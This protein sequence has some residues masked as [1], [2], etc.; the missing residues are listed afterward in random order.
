MITAGIPALKDAVIELGF[1]KG[2]HFIIPN[3]KSSLASYFTLLENYLTVNEYN[4]VCCAHTL[5]FD[6]FRG[7]GVSQE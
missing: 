6:V 7:M 1:G 5:N 2:E 4:E 3:C